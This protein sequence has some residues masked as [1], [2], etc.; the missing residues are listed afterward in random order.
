MRFFISWA[1][2]L[3]EA[4]LSSGKKR[5]RRKGRKEGRKGGREER[6]THLKTKVKH[7]LTKI[8]QKE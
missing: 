1:K 2:E 5:K 6:K 4:F 8:H 7:L 3:N